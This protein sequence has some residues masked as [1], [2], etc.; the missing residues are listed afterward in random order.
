MEEQGEEVGEVV[1]FNSLGSVVMNIVHQFTTVAGLTSPSPVDI[2]TVSDLIEA[3]YQ[4]LKFLP[5]DAGNDNA[6][7]YGTQGDDEADLDNFDTAAGGN[8]PQTPAEV[9][10]VVGDVDVDVTVDIFEV[11]NQGGG[12]EDVDSTPIVEGEETVVEVVQ[13]QAEEGRYNVILGGAGD[14]TIDGSA[15]ADFIYAGAGDDVV[16]A[17]AGDDVILAGTGLGDDTYKGGEGTDTIT[18]PSADE[19]HGLIVNLAEG[20]AADADPNLP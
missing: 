3:F 9:I 13:Q 14:D 8:E 7:D 15:A 17:G 6:N 5:V 11:E 4:A 10:K 20:T 19:N 12:G 16:D 1:V 18:F 2:I